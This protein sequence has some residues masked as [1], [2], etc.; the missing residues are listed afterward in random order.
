[1]FLKSA[2]LIFVGLISGISV[3]A[4]AFAFLLVIGVVPRLLRTTNLMDKVLLIEMMVCGGVVVGS[5]CSLWGGIPFA[6]DL[7]ACGERIG[8]WIVPAVGGIGR[9]LMVIY[10][11]SSGI[12][13]GCIAVALAEILDT[14]PI[15]FRRMKLSWEMGE[16]QTG[17]KTSLWQTIP[18][19][20]VMFA[21]AFGKMTGS[22]FSFFGGYRF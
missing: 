21:M 2:I 14:F 12:F 20:W 15:M 13:V 4:G 3:S 18:L 11:V 22:L 19:E 6:D 17:E 5:I 8:S 10:G 7:A 9:V 1:M 16:K